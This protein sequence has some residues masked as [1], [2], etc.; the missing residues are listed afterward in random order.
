[1]YIYIYT[2]AHVVYLRVQTLAPY[3]NFCCNIPNIPVSKGRIHNFQSGEQHHPSLC[4]GGP[5]ETSHLTSSSQT[6]IHTE[7]LR[8]TTYHYDWSTK[9]QISDPFVNKIPLT[10]TEPA[11]HT[12]E[13]GNGCY[14]VQFGAKSGLNTRRYSERSCSNLSPLSKPNV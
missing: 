6:S 4:H 13:S 14:K 10:I 8:Q 9:R 1:M 2:T 12:G 7:G 5:W 11:L 3:L